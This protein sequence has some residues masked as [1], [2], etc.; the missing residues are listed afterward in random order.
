MQPLF[1]YKA[2]FLTSNY[3]LFIE[4]FLQILQFWIFQE[5]LYKKHK[6]SLHYL[7]LQ[8]KQQTTGDTP[9]FW[10]KQISFLSDFDINVSLKKTT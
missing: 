3:F 6:L 8:S 9:A 10:A 7:R 5:F 1:E 4:S 2:S